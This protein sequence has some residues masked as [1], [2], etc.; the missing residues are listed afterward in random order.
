MWKEKIKE[1]IKA[2]CVTPFF[3]AKKIKLKIRLRGLP[4]TPRGAHEMGFVVRLGRAAM[5]A[6]QRRK[7][8]SL[9]F[10]ASTNK[11][12][13]AQV[14]FCAKLKNKLTLLPRK[15]KLRQ[16]YRK[17]ASAFRQMKPCHRCRVI[18]R[19]LT[20]SPRG[21]PTFPLLDPAQTRV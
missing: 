10:C 9:R 6:R 8:R 12:F 2:K 14:Y 11:T 5:S 4:R 16:L 17:L 15:Q 19:A 3:V 18:S 7:F 1:P 21:R 13:S 20:F